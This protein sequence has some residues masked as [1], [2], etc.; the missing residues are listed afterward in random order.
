MERKIFTVFQVNQYI[1]SLFEN[2]YALKSLWIQG[3]ISNF[4]NHS[5][6]HLYFT[7]KD[8]QSS[9]NCVMFK[10][11][12]SHLEF[13]LENGMSI[14]IFGRI[15]TYE[16]TGQYQLYAYEI[17]PMGK[18]A[19]YLAFEQLKQKLLKE[20]LFNDS[21]K[22]PIPKYPNT[23]GI[24]TSGT[25]AAVRDIIQISKRRNPNIQLILIP[26]L[27][28]G[29][30][31]SKDI[32]NAIKLMN[33]WSKADVIILG[34]GGGSIED[35]WAFNEELTVRAV[36]NSK[37]PIISAVGHEIDYT[38]TDFVSDM[39]APT[40]SAATEIAVPDLNKLNNV[41]SINTKRIFNALNNTLNMYQLKLKN[42][43][44][45]I[46]SKK[47]LEQ[48]YQLQIYLEKVQKNI[49][50]NIKIRFNQYDKQLS[51]LN[52]NLET[53][54][55]LSVLKRG[56]CI[57]YDENGQALKYIEN[58]NKDDILNI[59]FNQGYLVV[60]TQSKGNNIWQEKNNNHS[61]KD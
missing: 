25:G 27:V 20:G 5:S 52:V 51:N 50:R 40:P 23:I 21:H 42:I 3:E 37:I 16:K 33:E 12:A 18:G 9:I 7:L 58:I 6:G 59:Q 41:I 13:E 45:R 47:I 10:T 11:S 55:P 60:K 8:S 57:T 43:N 15:S 17:Q 29:K 49:Y 53:L 35:L 14:I 22:K 31:A 1:N 26:V 30:D 32:S 28:Q 38:I 36:Y 44:N 39:R 48:I 56:Y 46:L 61:K 24:I 4:K 54:S 2:D 19:L 34:R